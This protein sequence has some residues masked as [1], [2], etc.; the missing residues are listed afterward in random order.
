[1]EGN[2][3]LRREGQNSKETRFVLQ[4]VDIRIFSLLN[5]KLMNLNIVG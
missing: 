2:R 5:S 3:V 4:R 1:M